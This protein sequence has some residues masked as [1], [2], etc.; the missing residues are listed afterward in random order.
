MLNRETLRREGGRVLF[1]HFTLRG[2]FHHNPS[3]LSFSH[4][5]THTHCLKPNLQSCHYPVKIYANPRAETKFLPFICMASAHFSAAPDHRAGVR[6]SRVSAP[7]TGLRPQ[8]G[9]VYREVPT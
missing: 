3:N 6:R 1:R 5:N 2:V 8:R 9:Q 7:H 4:T